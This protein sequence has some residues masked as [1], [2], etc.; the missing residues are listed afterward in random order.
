[1]TSAYFMIYIR[2]F[3]AKI[4][5]ETKGYSSSTDVKINLAMNTADEDM[6][7]IVQAN[8]D[9]VHDYANHSLF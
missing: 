8:Y 5:F 1:M 2:N 6:P 9:F 4:K 7:D 3:K